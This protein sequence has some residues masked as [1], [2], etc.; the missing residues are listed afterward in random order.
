MKKTIMSLTMVFLVVLSTLLATS[1]KVSAFRNYSGREFFAD[2]PHRIEPGNDIP[3]T[4]GVHDAE[5]ISGFNLYRVDI[6]DLVTNMI[7]ASRSYTDNEGNPKEIKARLWYDKFDLDPDLFQKDEGEARISVHF[8]KSFFDETVGPIA[9]R[10]SSESLPKWGGWYAGDAH[11]HSSMTDNAAA[12]G[13][14]YGEFGAPVD[15]IASS[16]RAIGLDWIIIT[17]HSFDIDPFDSHPSEWDTYKTY[18]DAETITNEFVCMLGEE[19]T[20]QDEYDPGGPDIDDLEPSSHYLAYGISSPV[21]A[22][23]WWGRDSNPTQQGAI[24]DVKNNKGGIGFVAHPYDWLWDWENWA[25]QSYTGIEIWNG[26][27]D[28]GGLGQSNDLAAL[29]KWY[30]LLKEGKKFYAIGNSDTHDLI[31]IARFVRNYVYLGNKDLTESNVIEALRNGRSFVTDGPLLSFTAENHLVGET[32][33]TSE[34]TVD[35]EVKWKSSSEYGAVSI[36]NVRIN[37]EPVENNYYRPTEA[38]KFEGTK[39]NWRFKLPSGGVPSSFTV[40]C[41]TDEGRKAFTN[42]IQVRRVAA[43]NVDVVLLIDRS[44]SM[45]GSK[46]SEAKT[47]AKY[48]TDLMHTGDKIGVVTYETSTRVDYPLTKIESTNTK[49]L[50]KNKI[51][52][53]YPAGV[54]A[55][56]AGLRTAYNQLVNYGDPSHPWAIVLM[57]NGFHNYGEHPYNVLPALKSKN[58]KVYTIGLGAGA[59]GN[60]LGKIATDTGGFYR[61]AAKP[62]DLVA[63]Y[64]AIAAVVTQEQTISSISSSIAQGETT[65]LT[66]PLDSSVVQATF[67][68]SWGGSDLDLTLIK[69]DG[70][71]IDPVVAST[72]PHI[73]Y[74]EEARYEMYR[75][76]CPMMGVWTMVITGVSVPPGGE[77]FVA[78]CAAVAELKLQMR[79][80][81][82]LY[83]Y[84]Q[85]VQI[86]ATIEDWGALILG[87]NVQASVTRPDHSQINMI[88]FDDGLDVHGDL[89]ADDGVYTNNFGQ[90]TEDGS[91][92]IKVTA[93]GTAAAGE[94]FLRQTQKTVTISGIPSDT[95]PPKT[96][97]LIGPPQYIM[98]NGDIC[99]TSN[100]PFTLDAVDNNGAGSGVAQTG[101]RIYNLTNS[102]G[103]VTNSPPIDFQISGL[104]DGVYHLD[105]NSTDNA[106]NVE[107]TNTKTIIFDNNAPSLTIETPAENDALQDGVTFKVSAWDLG[108]VASV[109]FSIEC[110]QGNVISPEFQSMP[111]TLGSDGKWS[112]YFDTRKLPDGFYLF[113]ANGTDVLGN[114][115]ITTVP[116]SIRNWAAIELLPAS[117]TNKAGRTMPVKFSIRVKAS[118]DP[119]QPFIRNEELTIMIYRKGYPGTILQ[120]STYGTASTDYRI[121]P[122]SE[123][124]ITNFKTLSTPATYVVEIYRKG[125]LIG[126]FQFSTVK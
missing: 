27:F 6:A 82:D 90:Y 75:I 89:V 115:G 80:D 51:D 118:V 3:L 117:E 126:S 86:N 56:G 107:I 114:W 54:T 72:D 92:T 48:F 29:N 73:E 31:N 119:A 38:E 15:A 62:T 84:P 53:I 74:I 44:G 121:D 67:S 108:A 105:Y 100:T 83:S 14:I 76:E 99:V 46:I 60:L 112:L 106:G 49:T 64:Q 102:F 5:G 20:C 110:P 124:Y 50:V 21:K 68:V 40:Y 35:L 42:P 94:P 66:A 39:S 79:T 34:D 61:Y 8:V 77:S 125:M 4:V 71:L 63:I 7:V 57:S 87:A 23:D 70:S 43:S 58:I 45:A 93:T 123:K 103:W 12:G 36:I 55:M 33:A 30:S 32:F 59:D 1:P 96:N 104:D 88:L 69:P 17:D 120:T 10:V 41:E 28:N 116:F 47:S 91:Y 95:T 65:Q 98:P 9:V 26:E 101:Y 24:N 52:Q 78:G 11:V 13:L 19:I 81:K 111:A 22:P 2:A 109:T 37:G 85:K 122:V 25:V 18:C 113:A 97:L 16:A